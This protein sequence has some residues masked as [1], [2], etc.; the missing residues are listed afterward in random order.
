MGGEV[1]ETMTWGDLV[2]RFRAKFAPTIEVQQLTME[3]QD[4][5]QTTRTMTEII[6]KSRERNLLVP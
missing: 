6:T 2:T 5:R 1:L 4:R 3:F